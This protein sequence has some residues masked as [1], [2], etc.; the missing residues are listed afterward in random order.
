M[1]KFALIFALL[2]CAASWAETAAP[3]VTVPG[4]VLY[5]GVIAPAALTGDTNN[6]APSG[7]AYCSRINISATVA[8]NLTGLTG[9]SD[10][11]EISLCNTGVFTITLVANSS[12]SLVA[13]RFLMPTDVVMQPGTLVI[14]RGDGT[15]NGW[16]V[17]AGGSG[18]SSAGDA[19]QATI[20]Q[21][22]TFS[23]GQVI[24][25]YTGTWALA[26][27][28][29]GAHAEARGIVLSAT[30]T[31]FVVVYYGRVN[32]FSGLE[33]GAIYYL[34]ATSAGTLTTIDPYTVN[35]LYISKPLFQA[36]SATSGCVIN[37]RGMGGGAPGYTYFAG[38]TGATGSAGAAGAAGA[39]GATGATG[40]TG[41]TGATGPSGPSTFSAITSSTN[42]TATMTV[43]TGASLAT[44]GSGSIGVAEGTQNTSLGAA[45]ISTIKTG[46]I[47]IG[48][49]AVAAANNA[50]AVGSGAS[51]TTDNTV[52]IGNGSITNVYFG[53]STPSAILHSNGIKGVIDASS[54]SAGNIGEILEVTRTSAL[55]AVTGSYGDVDP[56]CTTWGDA[57][58]TGLVL[59]AGEYDLQGTINIMPQGGATL[60]DY[61]VAIATTKQTSVTG[62]DPIRNVSG[63]NTSSANGI[64]IA[65]PLWRIRISTQTTY[66]LKSF[67]EWTGGTGANITGNLIARR[68]R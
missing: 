6:Y 16:R 36:D 37:Y 64:N 58:A 40:S 59:Q 1:K 26:Q 38:P 65:T 62:K 31:S 52:V 4:K 7:L 2:F 15:A 63:G 45:S 9:M 53:S 29:T 49:G 60:G 44:S 66:Y 8:V 34:S 3:T 55:A 14:A 28:D 33:A 43:G 21:T 22:N 47:A 18:S 54:A 48:Y 42:T 67:M 61:Y 17:V 10:G 51:N 50:I 24:G 30:G 41:A 57:N 27:A 13:N 25:C 39:V 35:P 56:G 5:T 46:Q 32:G 19:L 12:S 11:R 23:A 20:T 68:V